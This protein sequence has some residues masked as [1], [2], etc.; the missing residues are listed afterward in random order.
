MINNARLPHDLQEYEGEYWL[1]IYC[2]WRLQQG[3]I[4]ITVPCKPNNPEGP[5]VKG[6]NKIV[7]KIVSSIRMIDE[8]GDLRIEFGDLTLNVFCNYTG[9]EDIEYCFQD[10][11]NWLLKYKNK[12]VYVEQGCKIR[13][14]E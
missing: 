7:N 11:V 10:D 1:G 9:N 13:F 3:S 4:P 5:L 2:N 6:V 8:C 14:E 12:R